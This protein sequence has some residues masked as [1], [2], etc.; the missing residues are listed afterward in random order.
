MASGQGYEFTSQLYFDDAITDQVHTQ[1]PYVSK[2]QR[3]LKNAQDGIF[4]RG[5]D[6]LLLAL[7]NVNQGY[8]ATFDFGLQV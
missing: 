2:G 1:Q 7:K 5:G 3:T 6:Q 4:Q 8:A